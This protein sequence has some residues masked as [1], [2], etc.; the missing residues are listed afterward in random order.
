MKPVEQVSVSK[1]MRFSDNGQTFPIFAAL[2]KDEKILYLVDNKVVDENFIDK[3][4]DNFMRKVFQMNT[5]DS[6]LITKFGKRSEG[7]KTVFCI[8]TTDFTNKK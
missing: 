5:D 3:V 2:V 6:D 7:F 1:P 4:D 8:W